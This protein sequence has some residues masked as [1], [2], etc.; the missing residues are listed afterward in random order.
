MLT[1]GA[2][3]AD[4]GGG[5]ATLLV[6][7][8]P[9][10]ESMFFAPAL[11]CLAHSLELHVLCVSTGD[12]DGLGAV[13]A[14]EL[15]RACACLGVPSSRVRVLDDPLLLDGPRTHWPPD[16]IARLVEAQLGA[17]KAQR[18]ITFDAHGVSRHA[19]HTEVQS[20]VELLAARQVLQEDAAAIAWGEE[21]E[22][23]EASP[24]DAAAVRERWPELARSPAPREGGTAR[25]GGGR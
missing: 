24:P 21:Q 18:V 14:L 4:D 22:T 13:R 8:H 5:R 2:P 11:L 9:D 19:N 23:I 25:L 16:H 7:A 15:P 3:P 10:D 20:G 12:Y 6:I 17:S 1:L